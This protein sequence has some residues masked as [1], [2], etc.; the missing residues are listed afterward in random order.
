MVR[1]EILPRG[2]HL[3]GFGFKHLHVAVHRLD[4]EHR[5]PYALLVKALSVSVQVRVDHAAI[6]RLE[7][8]LGRHAHEPRDQARAQ[9]HPRRPQAPPQCRATPRSG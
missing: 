8:L 6:V 4:Q 9:E 2:P 3:F 5:Q 7:K 1:R